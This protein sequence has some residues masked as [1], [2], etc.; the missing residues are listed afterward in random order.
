MSI[1]TAPCHVG[2]LHPSVTAPDPYLLPVQRWTSVRPG[3]APR[4]SA[5]SR[6]RT[7]RPLHHHHHQGCRQV[8]SLDLDS[9]QHRPRLSGE[10]TKNLHREFLTCSLDLGGH[11]HWPRR[12][13]GRTLTPR[14]RR[15]PRREAA[16]TAIPRKT[17]NAI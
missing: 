8:R 14:R 17:R 16:L 4:S 12:M 5:V 15:R 7:S 2:S 9:R 3:Q 6:L 1:R 11:Y 10:H 13:F